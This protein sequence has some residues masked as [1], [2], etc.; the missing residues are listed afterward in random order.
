MVK[1]V[2]GACNRREYTQRGILVRLPVAVAGGA[3]AA[4]QPGPP[5][6]THSIDHDPE[7]G[8]GDGPDV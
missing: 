1:G 7:F 6:S 4:R 2:G 3:L 8:V 5:G